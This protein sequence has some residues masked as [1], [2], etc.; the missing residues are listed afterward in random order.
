MWFIL[1]AST[2]ELTINRNRQQ[3]R[4]KSRTRWR[5]RGGASDE[6]L[7]LLN[8]LDDIWF[9]SGYE[10]GSDLY[11]RLES[12]GLNAVCAADRQGWNSLKPEYEDDVREVC[13]LLE[14]A[15]GLSTS[16]GSLE[17]PYTEQLRV[18]ACEQM[19]QKMDLCVD[20]YFE[21]LRKGTLDWQLALSIGNVEH[22]VITVRR[23]EHDKLTRDWLFWTLTKTK[24]TIKH[25]AETSLEVK[26]SQ[27]NRHLGDNPLLTWRMI[28]I[29]FFLELLRLEGS[30]VISYF[31]KHVEVLQ[32]CTVERHIENP[33]HR[34]E[35]W[36]SQHFED[37]N[38]RDLGLQVQLGHPPAQSRTTHLLRMRLVPSNYTGSED[39]RK[40][41]DYSTTSTFFRSNQRPPLSSNWQTLARLTNNTGVNPP[42]DR[43]N[44]LLRMVKEWRHLT[45]LKR[46]GRGHDPGGVEA[47]QHG[48]CAVLCPACPHR[49]KIFPMAGKIHRLRKA[50]HTSSREGIQE[51]LHDTGKQP[52]ER[53][54]GV[55]DL[56][57]GE[58]YINMDYLFFSTLQY[59]KDVVTL[60][61]SYDIACQWS[62]NIWDRMATYPHQMH[63]ERSTK[64]FVFLVPKFHLPAHIAFCQVTY[65]HNL[66]KGMGRT[67]G[68]APERG[69][70]NINPVATSTREM[71]PGSRR[72]TLDDHFGDFNWKKV[73]N[74]QRPEEVARWKLA[75]EG[76]EADRSQTNPFEVTT[77]TMSLAAVRLRLSQKEAEDLEHGLNYSLHMEVSPSV[78][79]SS[80][81]E[82]EDQQRRLER[83][84]AALGPHSTDLQLT[85]LQERSN[86]L[87]R[88]IEQWCKVQVL[89][90]P[91]VVRVRASD[92]ASTISS[93]EEK[94]YE[95]KLWLPSQL[96]RA[97]NEFCEER[98]CRYEWELRQAQAYDALDDLR[99]HL[100]LRSHLYKFK[101]NQLRGQ[102]A[103]TRAAG[104]LA[105]VELSIKTDAERYRRAWTALVI[106]GDILHEQS[107]RD[108]LLKL[109]PE[110]VRGMSD[111]YVGQSEGNRTLSWIWKARGVTTGDREGETV[112]ADEVELLQ[113]EMRRVCTFFDWH[114]A[115]WRD[116][117][118]RRIGLEGA[119]LEGL[120]AY[121]K[122]QAALRITMRDNCLRKW[123]AVPAASLPPAVAVP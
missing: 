1:C 26:V 15:H 121:A 95:V 116:Q 105:K 114:A 90:I 92:T 102:R 30:R 61:V 87:Q 32:A 4:V 62:K 45:L 11:Q 69:W 9:N 6:T 58:R 77:T 52:Q 113:E 37:T 29:I 51:F 75:I 2:T 97:S 10:P 119:E 49:A 123:R 88:K 98:L 71:G 104:V 86:A 28:G 67:D 64:E 34:I 38:L 46:S 63:V 106:L 70:A 25:L 22:H 84:Y 74:F 80:G 66:I 21:A 41:F 23:R 47:T 33:T 81:I 16:A 94:P 48:A 35:Y 60:N 54:C 12:E 109:E 44:A 122:R 53:P 19:I 55:G 99:R 18:G 96:K 31:R 50:G 118:S 39:Y 107:W 101:A 7:E 111:G 73:T 8:Q 42:K 36:N 115:W 91:T 72:D 13:K 59:S 117:A 43:Y 68:E 103:N 108:E 5:R 79:V 82:I 112:L 120:E 3:E 83:E 100:R 17:G 85:K 24:S 57:K 76:W 14:K 20:S 89:Y 40:H 93:R 56:Q 27:R 110:H 78:L 65:S